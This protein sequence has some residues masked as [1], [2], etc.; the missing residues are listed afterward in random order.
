MG[1]MIRNGLAA[2]SLVFL[3]PTV[4]FAAPQT[5]QK[6]TVARNIAYRRAVYQSSAYDFTHVG[7]LVTDG[8]RGGGALEISETRVELPDNSPDNEHAKFAT[9][10]LGWVFSNKG[11]E[12][13]ES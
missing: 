6:A 5:G 2:V 7:H 9:T 11:Q 8:L 3:V 4:S 13:Q 10:A 12:G 1:N